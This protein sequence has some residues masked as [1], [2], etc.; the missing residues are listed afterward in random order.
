MYCTFSSKKIF[1]KMKIIWSLNLCESVCR[2]QYSILAPRH[3]LQTRKYFAKFNHSDRYHVY[4][5]FKNSL[6]RKIHWKCLRQHVTETCFLGNMFLRNTPMYFALE[7]ETT[8]A[9]S[10]TSQVP[11]RRGVARDRLNILLTR[12]DATLFDAMRPDLTRCDPVWRQEMN[13]NWIKMYKQ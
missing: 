13:W 2:I 4:W 1:D 8:Y 9:Q 11:A 12:R 6:K 10:V 7:L 5:K 3:R